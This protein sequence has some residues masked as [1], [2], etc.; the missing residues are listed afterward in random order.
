MN[1]RI[2]S[3]HRNRLFTTFIQRVFLTSIHGVNNIIAPLDRALFAPRSYS[4]P[5]PLFI[6]GSPRSG[7][8]LC[9]QVL[10]HTFKITYLPNALDYAYGLT[11]CFFR[12]YKNRLSRHAPVFESH[13]GKTKGLFSPSEAFGFW[14]RWFLKGWDDDHC[15]D[16]LTPEKT[17]QL[18]QAIGLL[19]SQQS[20]PL[21]VKSLYLSLSIPALASALPESRFIFITRDP[22]QVA[23]SLLK[24]RES[25]N[26]NQN[27]WWSIRPP[28]FHKQLNNKIE[29]RIMW[30]VAETTYL[31]RKSLENL[32]ENRWMKIT[33]SDLC[34]KPREVTAQIEEWLSPSLKKW[35]ANKLP[36][37]FIASNS[38]QANKELANRL[39]SSLYYPRAISAI[40]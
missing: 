7:S 1:P 37:Q 31:I 35:P 14:H 26:L 24:S 25:L 4:E 3:N 28:G 22:I 5:T 30:Q 29:D 33:Y 9:F 2:N 23:I 18:A 6:V 34:T 20:S 8:T 10:A 13:L 17:K 15:N 38:V 39:K 16:S 19:E 40:K 36:E 32:P 27:K 11:H 21:L 12:V